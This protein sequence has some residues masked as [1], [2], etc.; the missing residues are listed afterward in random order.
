MSVSPLHTPHHHPEEES[1]E[2]LGDGTQVSR[3]GRV[4][5]S[6]SSKGQRWPLDCLTLRGLLRMQACWSVTQIKLA[7]AYCHLVIIFPSSVQKCFQL[8]SPAFSTFLKWSKNFKSYW[9][10]FQIFLWKSAFRSVTLFWKSWRFGQ[11]SLFHTCWTSPDNSA[12]LQGHLL[13]GI[14]PNPWERAASVLT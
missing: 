7:R 8:P 10:S 5:E 1:K 13:A 9:T 3:W 14:N 6:E 12:T 11:H 2:F 4:S